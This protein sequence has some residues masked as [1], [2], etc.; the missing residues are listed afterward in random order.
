LL[1]IK[2]VPGAKNS[3]FD[4]LHGDGSLKVR[5]RAPPVDGAANEALVEL[6]ARAFSL[7]KSDVEL[8]RGEKSRLKVLRLPIALDAARAVVDRLLRGDAPKP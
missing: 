8:V 7:R 2:A 6:A 4:G 1:S 5:L 3:S